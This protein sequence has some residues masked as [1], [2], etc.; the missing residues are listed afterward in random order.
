MRRHPQS[1]EQLRRRLER[2]RESCRYLRLQADFGGDI[3]LIIAAAGSPTWAPAEDLSW[4][5]WI[6]KNGD[7]YARTFLMAIDE[8]L[9]KL[10]AKGETSGE[11]RA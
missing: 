8:E 2:L 11:E 3:R 1:L 6:E 4:R 5:S 9:E 10:M 7:E